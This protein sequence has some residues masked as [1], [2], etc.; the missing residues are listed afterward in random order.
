MEYL[1]SLLPVSLDFL[2]LLSPL[3]HLTGPTGRPLHALHEYVDSL[4]CCRLG[5]TYQIHGVS[6]MVTVVQKEW[7][8]PR[9]LRWAI[10]DHKFD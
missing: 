5:I 1:L 8:I 6:W 4:N 2:S 7:R 3:Q 10:V 9:G